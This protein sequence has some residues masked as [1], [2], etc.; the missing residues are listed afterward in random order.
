M[1]AKEVDP[2]GAGD[3]FAA[4]FLVALRERR[5]VPLASRFATAAASLSVEGPGLTAIASRAAVERRAAS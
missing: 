2:T 1:A 3:V 5:P 4:A